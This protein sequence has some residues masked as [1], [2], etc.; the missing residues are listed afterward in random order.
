MF[1]NCDYILDHGTLD[2]NVSD[3]EAIFIVRKKGKEK[4]NIIDG[5]GRSYLNYNKEAFQ[6]NVRAADWSKLSDTLDVNEYW[7][8]MEE[9]IKRVADKMYPLRKIRIKEKGDPWMTHKI[10]ELLHDKDRIRK[11]AKKSGR[12]ED[13]N[14]AKQVQ[15]IANNAIKRAKMDF[16]KETSKRYEKDT[17]KFWDNINKL[18]PKKSSHGFINL[19]DKTHDIAVEPKD[20]VKFIN[21]YFTGIG[22]RLARAFDGVWYPQ[23]E[24]VPYL[25][26]D[27][28]TNV[29]E[30][31]NLCRSIECHKSS[32]I[33]NL[34][35]M[36]IKDAFLAIPEL[37]TNCFNLSFNQGVFPD[38]WKVARIIP[39]FKGGGITD[40]NNYRPVSLLPL[41]GK[42]IEKIV[43]TR[44]FSYLE[45]Y[46]LLNQC[47][48]GF[49]PGRSTI[50]TAAELTDDIMLQMNDSSCTL[51]TFIDFR[52]AFDTVNHNILLNKLDRLGIHGKT[53]VW[54]TSYLYDRCQCTLANG[55]RSAQLPITCGVPQGSILGPLLFLIYVNDISYNITN[56]NTKLYADDTVIY[57]SS[58]TVNDAFQRVQNDLL[59]LASWCNLN[60]LTIN[61]NKTKA[62]LFG[63]KK[64]TTNNNLPQIRIGGEL[65]HYVKDYK[66]LG[67]TLDCRLNF[68]K[69]AYLIS[70]LVSH[71]LYLLGKIRGF[72]TEHMALS[73]YKMKILPY[74]DYGDIFYLG[75]HVRAT[76]KLQKLQ[77]R[78]L[79]ICLRS[80]PRESTE[81]LH[82]K[83]KVPLLE[84]RRLAHLRNV[85]FKRKELGIGED[86]NPSRTR[87]HDAYTFKVVPARNKAFER[88]ICYKGAREWNRLNV[89][90]PVTP[91]RMA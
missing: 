79:R 6:A 60:Q 77:N 84:N 19:T 17:K 67:V 56:S 22:P 18:L 89:N 48:G 68:E 58:K 7:T 21:E 26:N 29:D 41:P 72:L 53:F 35:S 40:V 32:S 82:K 64:F 76:D 37:V 85:M 36:L 49:R 25:I 61:I 63:T 39:L 38:K 75:T 9:T 81:N 46:D 69:Y 1:S 51:A 11:K 10:I 59:A 8:I 2:L 14:R 13:W 62:V 87:I 5:H 80:A 33:E 23:W 27:I 50:D 88:S 71:K 45:L 42:L 30:V 24:R 73:I 28:T 34:S 47:Q 43:R 4:F 65:V 54:L 74:F 52:K 55:I 44:L 90:G 78:A 3:H 91:W 86:Q 57:A 16:I 70:K 31:I 20:T 12:L 83:A 66:Y 15:N